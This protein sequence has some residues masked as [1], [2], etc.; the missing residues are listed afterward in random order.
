MS[1]ELR[2]SPCVSRRRI[3]AGGLALL[4]AGGVARA[5]VYS[6]G[7][8]TQDAVTPRDIDQR[9]EKRAAEL[10]Q[11]APQ[12]ADRY[13]LFD[14][15]FP[16][17]EAEYRAVGKHAL[18]LIAAVSKR[19]EELPLHRVYTRAGGK[20]VDCRKLGSRR[21]ELPAGSLARAVVGRYREDALYLAPVGALV[22][23]GTLMCDFARNRSGFVVSRAAFDPPDFIR[24][25]HQ[26]AAATP[27]DAAVRALAEREYPGFGI[28]PR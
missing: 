15:A 25:D 6:R 16:V 11:M 27:D 14:L 18:I 2:A 4:C 7:P 10:R 9:L 22:A 21:A 13:V 19:A 20:D 3:V 24:A 17:D 26:A 8:A 23:E 5:Q 1:D 28:L 12:G